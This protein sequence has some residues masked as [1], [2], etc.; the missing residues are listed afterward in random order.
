MDKSITHAAPAFTLSSRTAFDHFS[1]FMGL[2]AKRGLDIFAALFGLVL[3]APFFVLIAILIKR[4]GPG[5]VFY[6]GRRVGRNGREFAILKF[7]T[8]KEC[9]DSYRGPKVTAWDDPRITSVGRW[10]RQTKINELPQFWNVLK[11]EMSV[12]GPRPEDPEIVAKWT[13]Q[14]RRE[15]LSIRPGITSPAS[16]LYR[17]EEQLLSSGNPMQTYLH[18]VLPTKLRLDQ[19]YVRHRSIWLDLDIIFWTVLVVLPLLGSFA[20]A[21][22]SLFLGPVA[23]FGRRYMSWFAVDTV[24]SLLAI[25]TAGI[26]W[27]L[28]APLEIGAPESVG[29]AL[30]FSLLFSVTAWSLGMHRIAWSEAWAS[31]AWG[32]V[33]SVGLATGVALVANELWDGPPVL[34]V[35][36]IL[37]AAFLALAGFVTVRYRGRLMSGMVNRWVARTGGAIGARER[38]LIV[39]GGTAGQFVA[40]L[41]GHGSG[42]SVFR[43]VGFVDDDLYK[44]GIQYL[45][46]RVVGRRAD[47]PHLVE[48]EDVGILVFAIHNI[49]PMERE[50]VLAIC[51]G[52]AARLLIVPDIMG[53]LN[54]IVLEKTNGGK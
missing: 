34:P 47:I 23:R 22:E 15:V 32:L 40:W 33:V 46:T 54:D 44:Q 5:P 31:D 49:D 19:L 35:G 7:R 50:R 45:G 20:P 2:L 6:R 38:V 42:A 10:L 1:Q 4:D 3:L 36:M 8:M 24:I 14:V 25:G 26:L 12:V 13:E 37:A 41:L 48:R 16:V 52:T 51:R 27:R 9:P 30:A 39:G 28:S 17:D 21:E 11:G 43:V 29:I 18:S 53:A